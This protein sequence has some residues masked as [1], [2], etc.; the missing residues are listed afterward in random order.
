MRALLP[1]DHTAVC[2]AQLSTLLSAIT[3][4]NEAAVGT[5]Y[6]ITLYPAL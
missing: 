1:T 2:A 4:A 3:A 5:A 6:Y